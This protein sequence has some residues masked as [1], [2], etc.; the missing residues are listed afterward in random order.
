MP[1]QKIVRA[2][3]VL[4][5]ATLSPELAPSADGAVLCQKPT[6][7]IVVRAACKKK[8]TALD[9]SQFG[10]TGPK[11]DPGEPG[12][13]GSIEGAP[14][15]GD[16]TGSYPAPTIAAAPAPTAVA[17]NPGTATD[18]CQETTPQTGVYCG[19]STRFWRGATARGAIKFW[20]DRLGAIH[21][22]GAAVL[23]VTPILNSETLFRLPPELRPTEV[24]D[25]PIAVGFSA[26]SINPLAAVLLVLPNGQVRVEADAQTRDMV[27]IGDVEF[28]TDL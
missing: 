17:A 18:P 6:G 11:G 21:I 13:A 5:A 8:E 12:P 20:R 9:L 14:A 28:R 10:A 25:F 24:L 7:V 22:R 15:G 1:M 19:T 2:A 16:L 4:V 23:T 3:G 27:M 26:G